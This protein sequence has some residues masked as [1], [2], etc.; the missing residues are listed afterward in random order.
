MNEMDEY[1]GVYETLPDKV[2]VEVEAKEV[3]I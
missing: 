1:I 2:E 3:V